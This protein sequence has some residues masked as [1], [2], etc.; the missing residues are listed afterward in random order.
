MA[1]IAKPV[2]NPYFN[3]ILNRGSREKVPGLEIIFARGAIRTALKV[4]RDGRGIGTLID[5]N[6]RVRDGG[7]FVDFF[8]LPVPSSTAPANL[9]SYCDLHGIPAVII[10]GTSV[11]HADGRVTAHMEYLPK[12]FETYENETEVLQDLMKISETYIRRYP[13]QYLWF[14][15]RFQYIPPECPQNLRA[16][17]PFYAAEASP[18]FFRK[19][20]SRA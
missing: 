2:K 18:G 9:K 4:L 7:V 8:G 5:Q 11:R 15:K 16:R 13:E 10:Y 14:Y 17:Y 12:P 19:K 1:A 6:T 3:G 20:K